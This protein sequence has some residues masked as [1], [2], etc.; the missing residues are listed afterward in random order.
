MWAALA[1]SAVFWGLR[2]GT[3]SAPLPP[4]ARTVAVDQAA[5]GDVL[6]LLAGP[7]AASA[8][9]VAEPQIASRFRLVG[10]MAAAN[11][12]SAAAGLALLSID[13]KPARAIRVGAVVDGDWVLQS[14]SARRV[15]IGPAGGPAVAAL[16]LAP[17]PPA[18]TGQLG[19]NAGANA[20]NPGGV[21]GAV[22][23]G[24][25]PGVMPGALPGVSLGQ[26]GMP[27]PPG[28]LEIGATMAPAVIR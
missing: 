21:S 12:Q 26:P 9:A 24:A 6:R 1:A 2:L 11:E 28:G 19:G 14:V 25:V 13:G 15:E 17:M 18:A 27:P 22:Q 23:P 20:G 5:R 3:R 7:A 8:T 4:Q 10:V 16:D